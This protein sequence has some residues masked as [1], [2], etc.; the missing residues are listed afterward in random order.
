VLKTYNKK[1]GIIEVNWTPDD[2]R[3]PN[4]MF[5]HDGIP[6]A[7]DVM[8]AWELKQINPKIKVFRT[9]DDNTI[10]A[11]LKDPNIVVADVGG[12]LYDHHQPGARCYEHESGPNQKAACGLVWE[13]W[14]DKII[15]TWIESGKLTLRD[16]ES[17]LDVKN[18]F[19]DFVLRPIE[20][21]DTTAGKETVPARFL[22]PDK[23]GNLPTG[24]REA[25][26]SDYVR[27]MVPIWMPFTIPEG[28]DASFAKA[29]DGIE[30]ITNQY[31]EQEHETTKLNP[32]VAALTNQNENLISNIEQQKETQN[33]T[34][35][36][37]NA[38]I[39]E[40][41]RLHGP[42][43]EIFSFDSEIADTSVFRGTNVKLLMCTNQEKKEIQLRSLVPEIDFSKERLES[44]GLT[45]NVDFFVHPQG[46]MCV[47]KTTDSRDVF[48]CLKLAKEVGC[49]RLLEFNAPDHSFEVE[50]TNIEAALTESNE[51][52]VG[53]DL[54]S[55]IESD[56]EYDAIE[57]SLDMDL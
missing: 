29:R 49:D 17:K 40:E 34:K 33:H 19:R 8:A 52:A 37:L 25:I 10:L 1:Y 24:D 38:Y 54:G 31:L 57:P 20:V 32:L 53:S 11:A 42:N 2:N 6:H 45:E 15:D 9:R 27:S 35:M 22:L 4:K 46:H 21:K 48:G 43:V 3:I 41:L 51:Q 12:G 5:V 7:D 39:K 44:Y 23:D 56:L 30:A 50:S 55:S 14:G 16:G 36:M 47:I 13:I 26:V 28:N 18:Q